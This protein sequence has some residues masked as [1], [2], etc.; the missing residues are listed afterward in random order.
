MKYFSDYFQEC[1]EYAKHLIIEETLINAHGQ[2]F[3]KTIDACGHSVHTLF[4]YK[5]VSTLLSDL[6]IICY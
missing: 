2:S 1:Q 6:I 3:T 5:D 4:N